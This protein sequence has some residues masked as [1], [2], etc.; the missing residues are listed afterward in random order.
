MKVCHTVICFIFLTL[1]DGNTV[2]Y[3]AKIAMHTGVEGGNITVECSFYIFGKWKLLCK[4]Q[5]ERGNILI[6]TANVV[7]QSGRYFMT[8]KEEEF[9][10]RHAVFSVSITQLEKSDAGLYRCYLDR[11]LDPYLFDSF[12]LMV[13]EASTLGP[14]SL[15]TSTTISKQPEITFLN[16]GF[17][18]PVVI[19]VVMVVLVLFVVVQLI[20]KKK[21]TDSCLNKQKIVNYK[22]SEI[23]LYENLLTLPPEESVY[24]SLD[25]ASRD[26]DQVYLTLKQT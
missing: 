16:S 13:T 2:P 12:Q 19:A 23:V 9:P 1:Q 26:E 8:Y 24:Q 17:L 15:S 7:A 20:C 18:W 11:N 5:C 22:K 6:E 10:T 21:T 25:P 3:N 4:N 14:Q